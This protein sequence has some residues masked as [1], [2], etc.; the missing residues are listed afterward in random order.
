[1]MN[2]RRPAPRSLYPSGFLP[3][4]AGNVG[5]DDVVEVYRNAPLFRQLRDRTLLKGNVRCASTG[6]CA[7]AP[8]RGR[9]R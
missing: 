2:R 6:M 4:A 9:T 8:G 1:M 5:R 7:G 3:I